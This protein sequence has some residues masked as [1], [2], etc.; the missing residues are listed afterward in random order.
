[1]QGEQALIDLIGKT[2]SEL[3][4]FFVLIIIAFV[5][6]FIPLYNLIRKDRKARADQEDNRQDRYIEREREIIKVISA[7]SEVIAGLKTTLELTGASMSASFIRV[8]ERIDRQNDL[9]AK[10]G[11]DMAGVKV[12]IDEIARKQRR[13]CEDMKKE[14]YEIKKSKNSV[15][16]S[17]R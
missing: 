16:R 12:F 3:I 9:C 2:N 17:E 5:I 13:L 8:H 1:M 7:N 14:F 10:C 11:D 6:G 15:R 4:L